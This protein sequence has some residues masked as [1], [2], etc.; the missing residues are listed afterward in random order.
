[1]KACCDAIQPERT[2]AVTMDSSRPPHPK[3]TRDKTVLR[4][5]KFF[6]TESLSELLF[7][8]EFK[9]LVVT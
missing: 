3:V 2:A 9:C 8:Q 4:K 1:M 5:G 7:Y 6:L